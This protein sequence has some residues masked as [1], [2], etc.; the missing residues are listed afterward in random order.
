MPRLL[1]LA[2]RPTELARQQTGAASQVDPAG[3]Y[4]VALNRG[5]VDDLEECA[6][7][8]SWLGC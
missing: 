3:R 6:G 7:R 5:D 1:L 2:Q 8:A 4:F